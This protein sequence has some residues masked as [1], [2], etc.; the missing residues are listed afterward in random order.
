MSEFLKIVQRIM[1]PTFAIGYRV[2]IHIVYRFVVAISAILIAQILGRITQAIAVRASFDVIVSI[3]I[4]A[5]AIIV[6]NLVILGIM[7]Y[8]NAT[9]M[10]VSVRASRVIRQQLLESYF[11][12][13][14]SL[15][16]PT[17]KV[18]TIFENG[19]S[20]WLTLSNRAVID[21][22]FG[23][24]TF[25]IGFGYLIYTDIGLMPIALGYMAVVALISHFVQIKVQPLR[26][27]RRKAKEDGGRVFVR[28]IMEKATALMNGA[29]EYEL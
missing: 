11:K 13:E 12:K 20:S 10:D 6:L 7:V 19:I 1:Q 4:E 24:V 14:L 18:L 15:Q 22:P 25:F 27:E 28:A 29:F 26:E 5:F 9:Q 21:D 16:T 2:W 23:I 3:G 8:F 17:G